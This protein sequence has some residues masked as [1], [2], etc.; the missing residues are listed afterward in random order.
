AVKQVESY[1]VLV[2]PNPF[3]DK[4][5][6]GL[7]RDDQQANLRLMTLTGRELFSTSSEPNSRFVIL[8]NLEL[9]EGIYIL[10]IE[11]GGEV[12]RLRVIKE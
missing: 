8:E 6:L 9:T 11:Q 1:T 5:Y 7:K 3:Q 12:Y 10:E 2:Y 4:L